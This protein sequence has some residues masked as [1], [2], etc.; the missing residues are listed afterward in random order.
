M[1]QNVLY[2]RWPRESKH[3]QKFST[4]LRIVATIEKWVS[5]YIVS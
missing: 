5:E 4:E 3:G 1:L 2:E